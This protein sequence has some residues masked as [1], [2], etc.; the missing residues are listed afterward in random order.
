MTASLSRLRG[1]MGDETTLGKLW[2]LPGQAFSVYCVYRIIA[3]C[4][5][6]LRR[7]YYPDTAFSQNDPINRLLGLLA[8]HWDPDVDTVAAARLLSF[9]M[10][11]VYVASPIIPSP[12]SHP[13]RVRQLMP[14]S[15]FGVAFSP[16]RRTLQCRLCS[17]SPGGFRAFCTMHGRI[18]PSLWAR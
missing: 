14:T 6:T 15:D 17:S 7:F 13:A 1:R 8:K 11:G 9:L 5:T 3:T 10:S 16:P 4:L 18:W 12:A 2:A